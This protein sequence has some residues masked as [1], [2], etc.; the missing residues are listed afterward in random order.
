MAFGEE[1]SDCVDP[2]AHVPEVRARKIIGS[3]VSALRLGSCPYLTC[4]AS[5]ITLLNDV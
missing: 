3:G 4:S 2:L 1:C 5:L